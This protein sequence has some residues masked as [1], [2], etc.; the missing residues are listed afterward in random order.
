MIE[1]RNSSTA[2][3]QG[4]IVCRGSWGLLLLNG[5]ATL[6]DLNF[7][8]ACFLPLLIDLKAQDDP[9]YGKQSNG[10]VEVISIH[11]LT[12]PV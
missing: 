4:K 12:S 9:D 2:F 8:A 11:G 10:N 5:Y 1:T 6:A 7:D 3:A